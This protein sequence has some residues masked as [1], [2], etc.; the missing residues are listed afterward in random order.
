[1]K[2]K[3]QCNQ[4]N[5]PIGYP[6]NNWVKRNYPKKIIL[7]GSYCRLEKIDPIK[8]LDD[9]YHVYGPENNPQN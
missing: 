8:H 7:E 2:E 5:Q 9:L 3:T 6:V 4:Y 1:M